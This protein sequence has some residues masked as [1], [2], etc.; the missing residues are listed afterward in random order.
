MILEGSELDM[1]TLLQG[2]L[3]IDLQGGRLTASQGTKI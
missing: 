1:Q 3:V 2:K